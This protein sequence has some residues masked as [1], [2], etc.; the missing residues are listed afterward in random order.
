MTHDLSKYKFSVLD[1]IYKGIQEIP[2]DS[3]LT[4]PDYCPD[5]GKILKCQIS[6]CILSRNISGDLLTFEGV[7][8]IE[9]FYSDLDKNTVRC[10]KSEIPF[11]QK[12]NIKNI[13]EF[14]IS[15]FKVKREYINCRAIS[16][17]RIDIHGAVSLDIQVFGSKDIE[18]T[19]DIS[20]DDIQQKKSDVSFSQ[21]SSIMQHQINVNEVL[22]IGEEKS[23]PEFIVKSNVSISDIVC[24]ANNEKL[25]IKCKVNLKILYVN[26]IETGKIDSV[27]FQ[28]P[29]N[30]I[31]DAPGIMDD[32][33]FVLIPE[34][35]SHDEKI[36]SDDSE[37]LSNLI[38]ENMKIIM[39]IFAFQ[40][41]ETKIIDDAYS[42]K[43]ETE[44]CYDSVD[45]QKF[46]KSF[47][48]TI[49]HKETLDNNENKIFK[50]LDIWYN[51]LSSNLTGKDSN[52]NLE[53]KIN[54]CILALDPE[55]VPFYFER[56]IKFS[57]DLYDDLDIK[58]IDSHILISISQIEY[59]ILNSNSLEIKLNIQLKIDIYENNKYQIVNNITSNE[60]SEKL[61]DS[62]TALT[63]YY[64]SAGETIWNIAKQYGTTVE[65]IQDENEIDFEI[66]D[67]D[68]A[69]LIPIV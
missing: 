59:K 50:I 49:V 30:D 51:S 31:V 2:I 17:R 53:G 5:I 48:E 13:S 18:I 33:S 27:E 28:I 66:L 54:L 6:T 32:N 20:S 52:I 38:T 14:A 34:I 37:S 44:L 35:I 55:F 57:K 41:D 60:N 68:R 40:S 46:S 9:L 25:N 63:I 23:V 43:Y 11:S 24:E 36:S 7:S 67:S 4:L 45:F 65:Q 58:N 26:D 21:L 12:V 47:D 1:K 39:S 61:K 56:E 16:P 62:D 10:F 64:A 29:V 15:T 42:T 8:I 22:E 19:N 69:I 3:D